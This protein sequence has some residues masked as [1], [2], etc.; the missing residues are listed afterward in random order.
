M[1]AAVAGI[2]SCVRAVA[3]ACTKQRTEQPRIID[4]L[5]GAD[6]QPAGADPFSQVSSP[7]TG[8]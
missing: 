5:L 4:A 2:A 8:A 3:V 6:L 7:D 1:N